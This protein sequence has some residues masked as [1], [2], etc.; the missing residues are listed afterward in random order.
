MMDFSNM[1]MDTCDNRKQWW[2]NTAPCDAAVIA[3]KQG[4]V[5]LHISGHACQPYVFLKQ[6]WQGF[7]FIIG[8]SLT[9][10]N[11]ALM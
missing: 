8:Y 1:H 6:I 2:G 7:I 4:Y 5:Q 3:A 9:Y 10:V 11:P